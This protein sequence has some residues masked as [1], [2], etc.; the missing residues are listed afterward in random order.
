MK[1]FF[2]F[3]ILVMRLNAFATSNGRLTFS[4]DQIKVG[5]TVPATIIFPIQGL[6]SNFHD[7]DFLNKKISESFY[8]T[9]VKDH[10]ISDNN[11]DIYVV[12]VLVTVIRS[13]IPGH[14]Q[15]LQLGHLDIRLNT[16]DHLHVEKFSEKLPEDFIFVENRLTLPLDSTTKKIIFIISVI[17]FLVLSLWYLERR[18]KN[19]AQKAERDLLLERLNQWK[20]LLSKANSRDDYE[21]IYRNQNEWKGLLVDPS[22]ADEFIKRLDQFVYKKNLDQGELAEVNK[23]NQEMLKGFKNGV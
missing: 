7:E 20:Q 1:L 16:D 8:I 19:K 3:L 17:V 11:H 22:N 12:N 15:I 5:E 4:S 10:H 6:E 2:I 9:E 23:I 13:F 21:K 18:R 14:E